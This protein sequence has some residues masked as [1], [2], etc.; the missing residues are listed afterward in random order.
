MNKA[1][2]GDGI[3][4]ERN[5]RLDEAEAGIK[6]ARRNTNNLMYADNT[7]LIAEREV[8]GSEVKVTQSCLTLC[9][10]IDYIV[11]GILQ[12]RIL[13]WVAIP[14]SGDL[15]NTGIKPRSPTSQMDSLPSRF[16]LQNHCRW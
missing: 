7:T 11:H 15:P 16:G 1:S 13:E 10:P 14:L 12:A 5:T 3:S 4:A 8:K 9:D 6:T 2:G